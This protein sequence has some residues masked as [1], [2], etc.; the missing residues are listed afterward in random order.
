VA[1]RQYACFALSNRGTSFAEIAA[2]LGIEPDRTAIRGGRRTEPPS[3]PVAH[4]RD[5]LVAVAVLSVSISAFA[6]AQVP[7]NSL[8]IASVAEE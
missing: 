3:V 8:V 2:V 4:R 7:P 1:V 5:L 6:L